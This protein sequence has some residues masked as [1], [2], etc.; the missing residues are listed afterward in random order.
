M[1]R[2]PRTARGYSPGIGISRVRAMY[3]DGDAMTADE[4]IE[5]DYPSHSCILGPDGM[6]L[7]YEPRPRIGF[8]LEKKQ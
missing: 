8:V 5:G 6:P 3:Y 4:I 1:T 2:V 7:E